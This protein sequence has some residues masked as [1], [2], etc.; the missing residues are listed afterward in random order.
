MEAYK[1]IR[2]FSFPRD[3]HILKNFVKTKRNITLNTGD[4]ETV[5]AWCGNS[6]GP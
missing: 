2:W 4:L 1:F 6:R 3:I 5:R